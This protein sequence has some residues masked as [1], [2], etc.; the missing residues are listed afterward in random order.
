MLAHSR[1]NVNLCILISTCILN[2]PFILIIFPTYLQILNLILLFP[3]ISKS[4]NS[5]FV[6]AN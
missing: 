3:I 1:G 4:F 2:L 5:Y 6:A